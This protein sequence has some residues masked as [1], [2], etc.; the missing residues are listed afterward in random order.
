[1]A[2]LDEALAALQ[3]AVDAVKAAEPAPAE[4][5]EVDAV[6][7]AVEDVLTAEGW[8]APL[9]VAEPATVEGSVVVTPDE[10]TDPT[11]VPAN[12]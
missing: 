3:A 6:R 1:M 9:P 4:P 10:P 8:T 2:S 7:K 5:A 12:G 11:A